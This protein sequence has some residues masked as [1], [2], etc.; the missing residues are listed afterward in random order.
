[1]ENV[2]I[3]AWQGP[4][5]E[6]DVGANLEKIARV[7]DKTR[8]DNLD[9]LC[10]PECFLTGYRAQSV[11]SSA[12]SLEDKA[13][14]DVV[15]LTRDNDTVLLVG[16]AEKRGDKAYNSQ[17]VAYHGKLLGVQTKTML[18]RPGADA[19][20]FKTDLNLPV[21]EAKGIKFGI[22]I[23]H[24]TSFVEPALYL[25]LKGARLLFTPHYNSLPPEYTSQSGRITYAWHRD[26]VLGNQAALA[27]LLKMVVVRSNIVMIDQQA[28][29]SGDAGI[30]NMEGK[31]VAMGTPFCEEVVSHCFPKEMFQQEHWIDRRE[32]PLELYRMI[33]DAAQ[34]YLQD[35]PYPFS[36][37]E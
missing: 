14:E 29:G 37:V 34:E 17:L 10:F 28:L 32:V 13:V 30:W 11:A 35:T 25:R 9:F 22:A 21:F 24:T 6:G 8:G 16:L 36:D 5:A 20:S 26:M 15:S 4:I 19:D 1:M 2:K 12:V 27:T 18:C 23:C 7:M 31:P 33:A 3:A